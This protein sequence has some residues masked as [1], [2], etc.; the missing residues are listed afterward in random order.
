M[1]VRRSP[2]EARAQAEGR[3]FPPEAD[4]PWADKSGIPDLKNE[5]ALLMDIGGDRGCACPLRRNIVEVMNN[6]VCVISSY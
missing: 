2:S 6:G 4:Q 1:P 5:C 3:G